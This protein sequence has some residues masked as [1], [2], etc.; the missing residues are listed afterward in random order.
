MAVLGLY[1][2]SLSKME[3][4]IV[5][6]KFGV[7]C[8]ICGTD[9]KISA[10]IYLMTGKE[11]LPKPKNR[12]CPGC[13]FHDMIEVL[14]WS[15][16]MPPKKEETT[17]GTLGHLDVHQISRS[18]EFSGSNTPFDVKCVSPALSMEDI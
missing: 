10:D 17:S 16:V 3:T 12:K 4:Y 15:P 11:V 7:R 18:G 5:K 1:G 6:I 13:G 2:G 8:L 14:S 9:F